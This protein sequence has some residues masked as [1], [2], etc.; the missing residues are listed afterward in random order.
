M[1]I[2]VD[3]KR[4]GALVNGDVDYNHF[5]SSNLAIE[6]INLPQGVFEKNHPAV[7]L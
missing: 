7:S 3:Y 1:Y 2:G 6:A 5:L 4:A